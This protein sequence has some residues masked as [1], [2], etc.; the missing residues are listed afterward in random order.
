MKFAN[1]KYIYVKEM[2]ESL[3]DRRTLVSM[4]VIPVLLMPVLLIGI[5]FMTAKLMR[6]MQAE[7]AKV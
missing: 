3:R 6:Q 1:I 2:T 4:I 7:K 5:G